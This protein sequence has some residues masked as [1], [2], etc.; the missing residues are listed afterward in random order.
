MTELN[1]DLFKALSDP[2]RLKIMLLLQNGKPLC[3][4]DLTDRLDLSQPKISR[5]LAL[6][7]STNLLQDERRGQWVYYCLHPDLPDW[8]RQ[9][10]NAAASGHAAWLTQQ[11]EQ[12]DNNNCC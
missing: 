2:T 4:C 8:A 11:R 9:V 1:T 10:L 7:R 5:H 6:L 3:V 12:P